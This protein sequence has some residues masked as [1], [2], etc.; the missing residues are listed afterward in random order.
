[1]LK[2]LTQLWH[3]I[4]LVH[5]HSSDKSFWSYLVTLVK[6]FSK[7]EVENI[8]NSEIGAK[9]Q[10]STVFSFILNYEFG[11]IHDKSVKWE[12]AAELAATQSTLA[13]CRWGSLFGFDINRKFSFKY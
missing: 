8:E 3:G 6:Q 11:A 5:Y 13:Y 2:N 1:M 12:L 10:I 4:F 9:F 7:L